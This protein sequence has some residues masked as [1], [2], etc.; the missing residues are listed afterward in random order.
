MRVDILHAFELLVKP[1]KICVSNLRGSAQRVCIIDNAT[2][3]WLV[4]IP[5]P[6]ICSSSGY[7][8]RMASDTQMNGV[9]VPHEQTIGISG[10]RRTTGVVLIAVQSFDLDKNPGQLIHCEEG[11]L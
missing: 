2:G 10:W 1:F 4:P 5:A 9:T 7:W 11:L 8:F 3:H 6:W